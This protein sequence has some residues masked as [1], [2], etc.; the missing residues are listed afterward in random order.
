V[1]EFGSRTKKRNGVRDKVTI[2]L[3]RSLHTFKVQFV[4]FVITMWKPLRTVSLCA[5]KAKHILP[6]LSSQNITFPN[7]GYIEKLML[8]YVLTRPRK[9]INFSSSKLLGFTVFKFGIGPFDLGLGLDVG[10]EFALVGLD[11][12][13]LS[14]VGLNVRSWTVC[15]CKKFR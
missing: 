1:S 4:A 8:V 3:G 10:Y 6:D 5:F 14:I 2:P 13:E 11:Q 9:A 12:L 15:T 7:K